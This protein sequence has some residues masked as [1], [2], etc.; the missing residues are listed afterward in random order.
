MSN[1][2]EN[3]KVYIYNSEWLLVR[4]VDNKAR[5]AEFIRGGKTTISRWKNKD[6]LIKGKYSV[7]S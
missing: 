6:Y 4:E 7:I 2:K 1:L 3:R 5:A